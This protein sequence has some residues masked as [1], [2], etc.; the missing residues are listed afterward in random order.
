MFPHPVPA[1]A[2]SCCDLAPAGAPETNWTAMLEGQGVPC[3][4][5]KPDK[6]HSGSHQ[7]A[8]ATAVKSTMPG[9]AGAALAPGPV[10]HADAVHMEHD[11][12]ASSGSSSEHDH[13]GQ[14]PT[15]GRKLL[16]IRLKQS[17][18]LEPAQV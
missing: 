16:N 1:V 2:L 10:V 7:P 3:E 18:A 15:S 5:E 4:D 6:G 13:S 12:T 8:A 9:L 11:H 14:S 17:L